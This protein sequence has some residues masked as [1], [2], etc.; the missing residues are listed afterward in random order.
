M[1]IIKYDA[2]RAGVRD[3]VRLDTMT[4]TPTAT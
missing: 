2:D 3:R 4:P 1:G